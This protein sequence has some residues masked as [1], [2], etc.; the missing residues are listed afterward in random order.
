MMPLSPLQTSV[1]SN[2]QASAPE[3]LVHSQITL[4]VPQAAGDNSKTPASKMGTSVCSCTVAGEGCFG[5]DG[6]QKGTFQH[7]TQSRPTG[8]AQKKP[9]LQAELE[10]TRAG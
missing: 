9:S 8:G 4:K 5:A 3:S 6:V 1:R 10:S 7:H 2:G